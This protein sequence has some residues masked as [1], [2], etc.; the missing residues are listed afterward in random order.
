MI[1]KS[2]FLSV[3]LEDIMYKHVKRILV[4][5]DEIKI[6]EV[7]KSYLEKSNYSV[8]VAYNGKDALELFYKVNPSL[9]L[10]DLML[11]DIQGEDICKEIRRKSR[12]PIIMLTAKLEEENLLRGLEI[13]A[14]DYIT[15]PFSP[16]EVVARVMALLRRT[17]DELVPL[18]NSL[19]YNDGDLTI[20]DASYDVKK[21]GRAVN[22]TPKE[23]D[24]LLT[25]IKYPS[26]VFTREELISIVLGGDYNGYDRSIDT[27]VKNLRRKIESDPQNP[28]YILTIH[29]VGYKF[30][31]S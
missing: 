2:S 5:D 28:R 13:G 31:G 22:L 16:K 6:V 15:K 26:K 25:L 12:V 23:Y 20:N 8:Y 27:H 29:G 17:D 7:I 10:L 4:V 21:D 19:S 1:Y 9:V 14:D 30:G 24:V 11:P 18:S 3:T